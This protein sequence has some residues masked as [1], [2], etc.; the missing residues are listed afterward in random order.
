MARTWAHATVGL[1]IHS[2]LVACIFLFTLLAIVVGV[3]LCPWL[4]GSDDTVA[5]LLSLP[6]GFVFPFYFFA[7]SS[8][9]LLEEERSNRTKLI[10]SVGSTLLLGSIT[11]HGLEG[12]GFAFCAVFATSLIVAA[13]SQARRALTKG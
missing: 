12:L 2:Y 6:L 1:A 9:V 7:L 4:L 3:G 13:C 5:V 10:V 8:R 11:S